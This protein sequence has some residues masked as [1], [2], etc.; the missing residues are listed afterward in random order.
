MPSLL[1]A[2]TPYRWSG[3]SP[4]EAMPMIYLYIAG[5]IVLL[6]ALLNLKTSRPDG[7]LL[8]SL[9][10]YRKMMPYLMRGRNEAVVYFDRYVDAEELL[11]FIDDAKQQFP[12]DLTHCVVAASAIGL[13]ENPKM[14]RFVA[15]RRLYQRKGTYV[16]FS[17]K[18]K[19]LD[20][21]AKVSI[22]KLET[23]PDD[24]F[25][26]FTQRM[27][28]NIQEERSDKKTYTDKELDLIMILPRPILRAFVAL[29]RQI[30]YYGL[31]PW[32]FIKGDA[33]YTSMVIANLGSLGMGAGYHHL[34]EWGTCPL[35]LM[36]GR[37]EERPVVRDG[38][39]VVRKVLHLRYSY[40]ERIDDGLNARFGMDTIDRVLTNPY[41][42]LGCL[43][44]DASD[45]RPFLPA[46]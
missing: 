5:G 44:D 33:M 24:T 43:K 15:G 38:E 10:K 9:H 30:D 39:V 21:E 28:G 32:S 27:S 16:T 17:M 45:R 19:R 2:N 1:P 14:N 29:V 41:E 25:R 7:V 42:E 34:Y 23:T 18:R 3:L 46:S 31:L 12:C 8:K 11:R 13:H 20:R 40:D 36:V 22:S 4:T 26:D 6:F 35:F 37:I